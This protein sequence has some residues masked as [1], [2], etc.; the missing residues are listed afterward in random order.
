MKLNTEGANYLI[1]IPPLCH[2]TEGCQSIK[3][4]TNHPSSHW[5]LPEATCLAAGGTSELAIPV[6]AA[7]TALHTSI[8]MV[9][10]LLDRDGH[11][12][13]LGLSTGDVADLAQGLAFAGLNAI[14]Y[15]SI[16]PDAKDLILRN[17]TQMMVHTAMGQYGD[18]HHQ[19][20][21]ENEY[22]QNVRA[23]SSPFFASVFFAGALAGGAAEDT[24]DK[25]SQIGG[26]YGEMI[27]I[28]DDLKDALQTPAAQDWAE[29][30]TCLPI[31]F[32]SHINHS[33][34]GRF[35]A[36][37][38]FINQSDNLLDAQN[39]LL[40]CGAVSYCTQQLIKRH[41]QTQLILD[42]MDIPNRGPMEGVFKKMMEPVFQLYGK[43]SATLPA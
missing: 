9:D 21:N 11:F 17:L 40:R 2:W 26:L 32:A 37:R 7:I 19:I 38:P 34:K 4:V 27:Q 18:A 33:E 20:Q 12:E 3:T 43:I 10:D 14:F 35:L 42:G 28:H 31:L 23:K 1:S 6:V 41:E 5:L 29:G 24:A 13:S 36:L 30:H 39:I 22:W 16:K 15:S 25:F 8:V